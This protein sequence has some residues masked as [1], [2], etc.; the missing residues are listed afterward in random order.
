MIQRRTA[1]VGDELY[2]HYI[3]NIAVVVALEKRE[4]LYKE[5][6]KI[7][8]LVDTDQFVARFNIN[9]RGCS[10]V[11]QSSADG[12]EARSFMREKEDSFNTPTLRK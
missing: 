3:S 6:L 11:A 9:F 8:N 5:G 10:G 2:F 7:I 1:F 12:H 4:F